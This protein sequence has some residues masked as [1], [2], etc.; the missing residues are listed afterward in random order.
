MSTITAI[1]ECFYSEAKNEENLKDKVLEEAQIGFIEEILS[2][3]NL[4]VIKCINLVLKPDILK[5]GYGGFIIL[6]LFI[7]EIICAVIY[8]KKIIFNK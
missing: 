2:S 5:K 3:S 4:Y 7:I 6:S 8:C 1:C